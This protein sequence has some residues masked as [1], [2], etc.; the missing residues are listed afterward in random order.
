MYCQH[1]GKELPEGSAFCSYCG[2]SLEAG[3]GR[4]PEKK[5]I[6]AVGIV[7]GAAVFLVILFCVIL[8][9]KKEK[10]PGPAEEPKTAQKIQAEKQAAEEKETENAKETAKEKE[11]AVTLG[12]FV[13]QRGN[14]TAALGDMGLILYE[15]DQEVWSTQGTVGN[16]LMMTEEGLYYAREQTGS[17]L[18][19]YDFEERTQSVI[20][21]NYMGMEPVGLIGS[22]LYVKAAGKNDMDDHIIVE[23]DLREGTVRELAFPDMWGDFSILTCG[24]RLYYLGGRTDVSTTPLYEG[25][26]ATGNAVIL[27]QQA[28]GGP[29]VWEGKLYYVHCNE[30]GYDTE[31]IFELTEKEPGS[32]ESRVLLTDTYGEMGWLKSVE[33]GYAVFDCYNDTESFQKVLDLAAGTVE[34]TDNHGEKSTELIG[35]DK[36][37]FYY[38]AYSGEYANGTWYPPKVYHVYYYNY[39]GGQTKEIGSVTGRAV[40]VDR[41][42]IYY[43]SSDGTMD[44]VYSRAP[45]GSTAPEPVKTEAPPK[46]SDGEYILPGSDSRYYR[47]L[48][49]EGLTAEEIRIARN[50]IYARHGYI[51]SAQDL[52]EYF[53]G[54]SWYTPSVPAEEFSEGML[55]QTERANLDMIKEYE[56]NTGINQ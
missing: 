26:P 7:A 52:Q 39:A 40:G 25:D 33:N 48:D 31:S 55:N 29:F 11:P 56:R 44:A 37:G 49:L 45:F 19:Y 36:E 27:E 42:Y 30:P 53:S 34:R 16:R 18:E 38:S 43:T 3:G 46:S 28:A 12:T 17:S 41:N 22:K 5:K 24:D 51:F 9:G 6:A 14:R 15:E 13:L 8:G 54:K 1:C 10:G 2:A 47:K 50:E 32:S 20:L 23:K 21:G 35:N 4:K